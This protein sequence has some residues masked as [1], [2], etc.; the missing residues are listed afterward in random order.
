MAREDLDDLAN[1]ESKEA[2]DKLPAGYLVLYFGLIAIGAWYLWAYS[3]WGAGWTQ[4][5]D[6]EGTP[7]PGV[8]AFWTIAFTA[9]AALAAL[10]IALAQKRRKQG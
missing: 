10:F 3:P 8:N 7:S 4:A 6:L 5:K 2:N 1:F 9:V